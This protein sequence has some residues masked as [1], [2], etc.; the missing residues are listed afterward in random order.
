VAYGWAIMVDNHPLQ[1]FGLLFLCVRNHFPAVSKL[2][3][4]MKNST[5]KK[6][7]GERYLNFDV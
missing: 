2:V 6:G 1:P 5:M 7:K 3:L 4:T